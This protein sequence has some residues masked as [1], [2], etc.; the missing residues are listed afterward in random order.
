MFDDDNY[1]EVNLSPRELAGNCRVV[2]DVGSLSIV[3]ADCEEPRIEFRG[4]P[5]G[6]CYISLFDDH[7]KKVLEF[8][9]PKE[10]WQQFVRELK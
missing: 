1:D 4:Q 9:V 7:G 6:Q 5:L 8:K 3:P 10:T 2:L